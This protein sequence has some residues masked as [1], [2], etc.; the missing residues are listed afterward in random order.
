MTKN[1]GKAQALLDAAQQ[2]FLTHGYS[3]ASIDDIVALSRVPK[4]TLYD[5]FNDKRGLFQAVVTRLCQEQTTAL[6]RK[7]EGLLTENALVASGKTVSAFTTTPLAQGIFRICIAESIR[8][9]EIGQAFFESGPKVMSAQ[10]AAVITRGEKA[11]DLSVSD[12]ETAAIHF[13]LLCRGPHFYPMV[14]RLMD[15]VGQTER[16]HGLRE[17][18]ATFTARY[19]TES[20]KP[21]M[22]EALEKLS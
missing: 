13:F 7:T 15:G 6:A 4:A 19:G 1:Y 14:L 18:L 8:F 9:P 12:K 16:M 21:R 5:H 20:F 3:G 17:G 10:V 22:A 11:G 2:T